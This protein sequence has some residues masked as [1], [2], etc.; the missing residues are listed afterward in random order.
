MGQQPGVGLCRPDSDQSH[1][2]NTSII[3]LKNH[4]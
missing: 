2:I 4:L 3:Y 1:G